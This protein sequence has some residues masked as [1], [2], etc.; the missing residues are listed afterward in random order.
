V[1]EKPYLSYGPKRNRIHASTDKVYNVLEQHR[2]CTYNVTMWRVRVNIVVVE[3]QCVTYSEGV[4]V[5]LGILHAMCM[6]H[7]AICGLSRPTI[8]FH[9][10]SYKV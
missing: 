7:I 2:Q 3:R 4:F 5:A 9:I 1:W 8:H 6:L 10:T